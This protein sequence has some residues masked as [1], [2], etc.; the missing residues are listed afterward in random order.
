MPDDHLLVIAVDGLRASALGAYGNTTYP[1]P[2]LDR[3]AAESFLLDACL[4]GS[5]DL[6]LIYRE[7]WR[8]AHALRTAEQAAQCSA[9]PQLLAA[10][11]YATTLVA[12]DR[13][14]ITLGANVEF[15][16]CV[17]VSPAEAARAED[18]P[19]TSLGRLFAAACEAIGTDR[20][21]ADERPKLVWVHSRGMH[22]PWDAPLELQG[23]LLD[24]DDPA[25]YESIHPPELMLDES[26]DP[27][28]AFICGCAYAA[29]VMVL[30]ECLGGL[31]EAAEQN[32][33]E[34]RWW[35]VLKG[36]RGYPLGEHGRVGGVDDRLFVEQLHVPWLLR[37]PD[38]LGRLARTAQLASHADLLP[39]LLNAVAR[40]EARE[41]GDHRDGMSLLPLMSDPCAA[42]RDAVL[43]AGT[44][45]A[46]AIRTHEWSLRRR[47]AAEEHPESPPEQSSDANAGCEL[48][49]RPDDRWE[50]NDVA[51][52]CPDVVESLGSALD[53]AAEQLE[54][55]EPASPHWLPES[56]R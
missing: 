49:V 29:Q 11:G 52:L 32:F 31:L 56:T 15:D 38:D 20:P 34:S 23:S 5:T 44:S 41:G 28:T 22:G 9:L 25:P 46:R 4:A 21:R 12:D 51:D 7:L 30:D 19:Q 3:L 16:Q 14:V 17:E 8:S 35:L 27:D 39:T 54:R 18:V 1:T 50:A 36:V 33:A 42:W 53:R 47:S 40:G 37:S 48:F 43:S 24:E 6:E 13:E 26:H 2:S 10:R 55:G 45:G